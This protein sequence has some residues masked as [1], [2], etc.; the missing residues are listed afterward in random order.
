MS[1][2]MYQL[3]LKTSF[4]DGLVNIAYNPD[5]F[6]QQEAKG[7]LKCLV[8]L[9]P[10]DEDTDYIIELFKEIAL[11]AWYEAG[12]KDVTETWVEYYISKLDCFPVFGDKTSLECFRFDNAEEWNDYEREDVDVKI[13]TGDFANVHTWKE[14]RQ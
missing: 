12:F 3:T 11:Y 9:D 4:E 5:I 8:G 7:C 14:I 13:N 1:K 2:V 10:F 6:T